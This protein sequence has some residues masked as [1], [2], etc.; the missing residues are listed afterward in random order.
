MKTR[1]LF[2]LDSLSLV[3]ICIAVAGIMIWLEFL[4]TRMSP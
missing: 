3:R 4:K 1:N 2:R